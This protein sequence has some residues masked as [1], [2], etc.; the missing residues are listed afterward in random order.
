MPPTRMK[1]WF[2]IVSVLFGPTLSFGKSAEA[3]FP[4]YAVIDANVS[5]WVNIYAHYA[6]T[7]AVVHDSV[8]L[9]VV[10]AVIDLEP[11]D[12]AGARKVNRQ[13]MTQA[14]QRYALVLERLAADPLTDDAEC[15]RVS[16]LF[17]SRA[18]AGTFNR[19]RHRVRCQIGQRDRFQGGL[20]RSGA[21]IDRM[22][23]ILKS[24]GVPED[25][26]Y[27]PH[28]ESSF[29]NQAY[30]KSGA[31]GMWQFTRSTGIRF[32]T[33]DYVL[34]ERRDPIA[35]THAAAKLLKENHNR[36]GSWPLAIT[37]YNH[38]AA[39]MQRAKAAHGDYP[40]I[41]ASYRGRS[42]KFASRNF[43]S[44]FLAARRVASDYHR[45]F[46]PLTLSAPVRSRSVSLDG[47]A[48]L[49]DLCDHFKVPPELVRAMNPALRPPVF[50]GQKYVPKGYVL[51]LPV[52][53]E[54]GGAALVGAAPELFKP[55]QKASRFYT[56]QQGETAG[57]IAR[58]HHV[59]LDDLVLANNLDRRATVYARQTLR[60]PQSGESVRTVASAQPLK[61]AD[62]MVSAVAADRKDAYSTLSERIPLENSVVRYR[63]PGPV[64]ADM[65][66][67]AELEPDEAAAA[68]DGIDSDPGVKPDVL[69]ADISFARIFQFRQQPAGLIHVEVEETL[70]H[71]AEWAGVRASRIRRLNNLSFGQPLQLHK[72]IIIPLGEVTAA[73]FEARRYEFHK[74][75]QEDFFAAYR[76]GELQRY[77][78]QPG[79]SYWTLCREKFDLPLWLLRHYN[80][81]VDL[82]ELRIHQPLTI[83]AI[84]SLPENSLDGLD[85]KA[86]PEA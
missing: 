49:A 37:A 32:M 12:Q 17:G 31:A 18:D 26:A 46:G 42:F 23:T 10:Y 27:L 29:N 41:V 78:V 79:D 85:G 45:Y 84:E 67:V 77:R 51:N 22:R 14:S 59:H 25:L 52:P 35:A 6:T 69:T 65:L 54:S 68:Q 43:Y 44:E 33:V 76:I 70:G 2:L 16:A 63:R 28:V 40:A 56:V 38:G 30:S 64:P 19:A 60:I 50:S 48:A 47:F 58:M 8:D 62:S 7:Q 80:A 39:G 13:R 15:R 73:D 71:Y 81:D 82:A 55:G 3:T 4:E 57:K 75:L 36:L 34:D 72:Q 86:I 83:P 24:H 21:Y 61:P 5:F 53:V 74:R 66:A 9:D 11:A 20:I 1:I